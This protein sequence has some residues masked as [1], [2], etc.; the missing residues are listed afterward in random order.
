MKK[1]KMMRSIKIGAAVSLAALLQLAVSTGVAQTFPSKPVR[2]VVGEAPGTVNDLLPRMMAPHMSKTLGQ[3]VLIENRPGAG[4]LISY[5]Y[6]VRAEPDGHTAVVVSVTGL[7]IVPLT[8]KDPKIDIHK[9]LVPVIGIAEG[10]LA[11]GTSSKKPWSSLREVLDHAKKNPGQLNVGTVSPTTLLASGIILKG[12]QVQMV[13]YTSGA[14]YYQAALNGEI[15]LISAAVQSLEGF[16]DRMR[17]LAVSGR[18]RLPGLPSTPT[19]SELGLPKVA[20]IGYSLYVRAGTPSQAIDRLYA[21]AADALKLPEVEAQ[22]SKSRMTIIATPPAETA[23][24]FAELAQTF[25]DTAR[26]IGMRPQ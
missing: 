13:P 3:P 24:A 18:S 23:R 14:S 16:G 7:G 11:L 8:V 1:E 5:E 20:G 17:I 4:Q 6:V 26:E 25:A 2:I 12:H 21:S 22:V 10:V 15:D 19:F 9:D